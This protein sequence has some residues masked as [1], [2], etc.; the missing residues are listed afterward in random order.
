MEPTPSTLPMLE[1]VSLTKRYEDDTL[2]L[3]QVSFTIGA[4]EIVA[5]TGGAGA[6]TG[7]VFGS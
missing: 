6:G 5:L 3:D 4:G 1:A 7:V 2:A